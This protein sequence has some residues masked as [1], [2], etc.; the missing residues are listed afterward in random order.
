MK[1]HNKRLM[2]S[3]AMGAAAVMAFT[4][5]GNGG[6]DGDSASRGFE[7]C[8]DDPNNC[9]FDPNATGDKEIVW[10]ID[11]DWSGWSEVHS[12]TM[13]NYTRQAIQPV[14]PT[15]G[16]WLPDGSWEHNPHV[17]TQEPHLVSEE[18]LTV[19][20]NLNPEGGWGDGTPFS[21]DDFIY[22]W[23][24]WSGDSDLCNEQCQ[25]RTTVYGSNVAD[26]EEVD[27]N[28][29]HVV[30]RDGY[31]TPEWKYAVVLTNPAHL[32][33]QY[34]FEDWKSDP[35]AMGESL[36]NFAGTVPEY[37]AGPYRITD[38]VIGDYIMLEPNEEWTGD[39]PLAQSIR[40]ESMDDPESIVT[41]I[42]QGSVH[43]ASMGRYDPEVIQTLESAQE[44]NFA[45]TGGSAWRHFTLNVQNEFLRDE[46]LRHAV[47]T[48]ID[49]QHVIDR[50]IGLTF[51]AAE[52]KTNHVFRNDNDNYHVDYVAQ[53]GHGSGDTAAARE[54]LEDAG[55]TWEDDQLLT[56]DGVEVALEYRVP[57]TGADAQTTAEL[58]QQYLIDLGVDAS[59]STYAVEDFSRTLDNA[60]FDI[61]NFQWTGSP[62]FANNPSA[63][64][65]SDST[66]NY[67]QL[68]SSAV[69]EL[70]DSIFE[71]ADMDEAAARANAAVEA[72]VAEAY[73]LPQSD[74]PELLVINEN[75]V[76][77]RQNTQTNLNTF[78][79]IHEWG[80]SSE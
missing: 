37:S 35:V 17:L 62:E 66:S 53:A 49:V 78:Y 77:V 15:V 19:E 79:N 38:G 41:E 12:E 80:W 68:D 31:L 7:D 58:V 22:N 8:D 75:L 4:A 23:Y 33:E 57:S 9:N 30:Y 11:G 43:G 48:V 67:G 60:E 73:V 70:V 45:L 72:V 3:V 13:N 44:V 69:D 2:A 27:E 28:T 59:I 76:N 51:E 29:V 14:F 40:I 63:Q 42:R 34:G 6:T 56:P 47:L 18:P 55:Y 16:F 71:T 25:P 61:I 50:T 21:A 10:V 1:I 24:A 39:G 36:E 54:I 5:C 32:A 26:I 52:P 46:A 20:Y 74:S 64:W 65:R